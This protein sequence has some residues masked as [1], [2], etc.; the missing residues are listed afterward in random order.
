M[1]AKPA[2]GGA[3]LSVARVLQIIQVLSRS[4]Q[5]IG[6]A[7]LSRQLGTPKTSLIGLLRGLVD[8]NYVIAAD[9]AYRLGGSAFELA[10]SILSARQRHHLNDYIRAGMRDLNRVTG[11]TVFYGVSTG[12]RPAMMTYVELVESRGALRIS[13]GIGDRSPLYCTAGGRILLA[14]MSD[15]EVKEYLETTPLNR[16]I[17]G[18]L[19]DR[20]GL[21]ASIREAREEDFS[22]VADE[23]VQG[24]TGMAA[25]VRDNSPGILGALIIA[26]PSGRMIQD[27]SELREQVREAARAISASLGHSTGAEPAR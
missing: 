10:G 2:S 5:P 11:E 26:G 21:L 20:E 3:P 1:T 13:V 14:A 23:M 25:P 17:S 19:V 4:E 24:I 12:E 9:G 15:E 22:I 8:M 6:L 18:T 27:E 7:E 16:I